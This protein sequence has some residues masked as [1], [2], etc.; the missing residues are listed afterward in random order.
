M[1]ELSRVE[2]FRGFGS[3]GFRRGMISHLNEY[4]Q[5]AVPMWSNMAFQ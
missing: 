2:E 1:R 3:M 4:L 5:T